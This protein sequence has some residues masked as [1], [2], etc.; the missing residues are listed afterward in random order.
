MRLSE[1]MPKLAI[2]QSVLPSPSV[3]IA[4]LFS[5]RRPSSIA[6]YIAATIIRHVLGPGLSSGSW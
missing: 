6:A 4:V 5:H 2:K 1:R 3:Q